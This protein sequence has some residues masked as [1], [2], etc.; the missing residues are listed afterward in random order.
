[1]PQIVT[2][3]STA[4]SSAVVRSILRIVLEEKLIKCP[5]DTH[6]Y[7]IDDVILLGGSSRATATIMTRRENPLDFLLLSWFNL[8]KRWY[9]EVA[10]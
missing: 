6:V 2:T 1:M 7:T 8:V 10:Y 9:N 3:E 5:P 4:R